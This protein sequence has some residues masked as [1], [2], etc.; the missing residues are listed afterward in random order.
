MMTATMAIMMLN[1]APNRPKGL[2]YLLFPMAMVVTMPIGTVL[3]TGE[4]FQ[5]EFT[6]T[7]IVYCI[8]SW[9]RSHC[10][11]TF[12]ADLGLAWPATAI[13]TGTTSRRH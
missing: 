4:E 7:F 11:R 2:V 8:S 13:A 3:D 12:S 10:C 1:I 5:P 9:I 6:F